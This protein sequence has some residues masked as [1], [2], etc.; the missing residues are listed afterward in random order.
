MKRSREDVVRDILEKA[1]ADPRSGELLWRV[2]CDDGLDVSFGDTGKS[3]FIASATKLYVTTLLLQLRHEGRIDWDRP[4][5]D[6]V[7]ALGGSTLPNSTVRDIMAHRGGLPDYFEGRREGGSTFQRVLDNDFGWDVTDVIRWSEAMTP[8]RAS[9]YSDSGYQLLGAAIES[10]ADATFS[11]AVHS[12]IVQPLGL[13]GTY[14]FGTDTFQ[15]YDEIAAM[16]VGAREARIP[17]AMASVQ[18]DGGVVSTTTDGIRFLDG[19]FGG[20]LFPESYL[21][22]IMTDW[23]RVFFPL[24]YGLGIMRFHLPAVLTGFRRLP[25]AVGHSGASGVVMYRIPDWRLSIVGT[26]NQLRERSLPYRIMARVA[27]AARGT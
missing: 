11:E 6:Y 20:V 19:F 8:P 16:R 23:N 9:L 25:P 2:R 26:V 22:E 17:A 1:A 3:F 27:I 24:E 5:G 4:I 13:A 7:P 12:R 18:A 15:L 10:V 21:A 14:V